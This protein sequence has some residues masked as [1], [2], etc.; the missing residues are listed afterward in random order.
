MVASLFEFYHGFT[1]VAPLPSF[2]FG[3]L[4]KLVCLFV[5]GALAGSMPLA[6]TFAA[7]FGLA[8][9]ASSNFAPI[10]LVDIFGFDPLST[11]SRR[12]VYTISR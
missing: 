3:L 6:V 10:L 8:A 12:A 7:N 5:F 9:T 4:Q 11:S 1:S 2:L